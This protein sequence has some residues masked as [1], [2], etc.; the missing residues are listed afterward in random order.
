MAVQT[1]LIGCF[2]AYFGTCG[3]QEGS[4]VTQTE[5]Q[6][7]QAEVD[8][9]VTVKCRRKCARLA[10]PSTVV[11]DKANYACLADPCLDSA[12]GDRA[13]ETLALVCERTKALPRGIV[14][15]STST[16][17]ECPHYRFSGI[18]TICS[19]RRP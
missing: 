19:A 1:K 8:I 3:H 13:I 17:D 10:E 7:V 14:N 9:R 15:Y 5:I 18:S 11:A 6:Q 16:F 4:A 12:L 2:R